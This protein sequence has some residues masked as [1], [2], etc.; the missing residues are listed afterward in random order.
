MAGAA[1]F[2]ASRAG[3]Y[4]VGSTLTVDG[5]VAFAGFERPLS[6]VTPSD[7]RR[8]NVMLNRRSILAACHRRL[9][10]DLRTLP[11][12]RRTPRRG[13]HAELDMQ[14]STTS[15]RKTC[16]NDPETRHPARPRQGS[17]RGPEIQALR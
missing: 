6:L 9:G 4:V 16:A 8:L 1:I 11:G 15:S 14:C 17:E 7:L 5:G 2:L 3:D 13:T 12:T 10:A